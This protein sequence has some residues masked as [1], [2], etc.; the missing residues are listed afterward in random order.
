MYTNSEINF[1]AYRN[2][3]SRPSP[4]KDLTTFIDQMQRVSVQVGQ[5]P[6]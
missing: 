3:L 4:E 2:D 6:K 1:Q 5:S